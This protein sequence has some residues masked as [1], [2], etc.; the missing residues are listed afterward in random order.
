MIALAAQKG[1]SVAMEIFRISANYLGHLP[2]YHTICL[3]VENHFFG[4]IKAE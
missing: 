2:I 1:D 4:K 3:M